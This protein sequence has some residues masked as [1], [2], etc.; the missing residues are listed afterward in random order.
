[1]RVRVIGAIRRQQAD[2]GREFVDEAT[3]GS[4][5]VDVPCCESQLRYAASTVGKRYDLGGQPTC[6]R[7]DAL[8]CS[9]LGR[10]ATPFLA[11]TA[12]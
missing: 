4:A 1:M 6:R 8:Q 9:G 3:E 2:A 5:L 12:C 10:W 7:S 11:P